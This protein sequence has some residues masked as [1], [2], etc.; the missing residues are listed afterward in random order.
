MDKLKALSP[1]TTQIRSEVRLAFHEWKQLLAQSASYQV[2]KRIVDS[3]VLGPAHTTLKTIEE[4]VKQI[5]SK[6]FAARM[7]L[8]RIMI[9]LASA[10]INNNPQALEQAIMDLV[11]LGKKVSK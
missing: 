10:A 11:E 7:K 9:R 6:G 5:A 3:Q 8:T 4:N 1:D 2:K